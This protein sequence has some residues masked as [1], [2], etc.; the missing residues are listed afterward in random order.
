MKTRRIFYL[1]LAAAL[2]GLVG[3]PPAEEPH[4]PAEPETM[5]VWVFFTQAEQRY[6]VRREIPHTEAALR[7][8]LEQL[9]QGPTPEEQ[10]AGI[11]SWFSDETAG[12]LSR[13]AIDDDGNALVDFEDFRP[14]VPGASSAAGSEALLGELNSTIFQYEAV[15]TVDYRIHDSCEAFWHF[16]QRGCTIV[17]SP[18]A[19]P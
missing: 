12:M 9:L 3:C 17:A 18:S 6:P 4:P 16:L 8:T 1:S 15:A 5:E 13:V 11:T 2:A 7:A 19:G 14:I 10:A